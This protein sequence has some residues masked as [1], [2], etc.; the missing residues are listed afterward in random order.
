M[1][2]KY[3]VISIGSGHNGLIAAAYFA[4]AGRK[5]LV[6]EK[7]EH[8]GGGVVTREMTAP[9][10][11]HDEHSVAHIF[12]QAN[13]L[14]LNDELGLISRYGLKYT[15]PE[16]P[17]ISVFEDGSTLPVF[18]DVEKNRQ[19]IAQYSVRDADSFM[20]LCDLSARFLPMLLSSLY[21]PPLPV[22][23]MMAMLDQSPE[24]REIFAI[25]QKSVFDI[26]TEWFENEKV[27]IHFIKM[28]SENLVMPE[29]KGTGIG[30]F[31][32]LG[33]LQQYGVGVAVGGSGKLTEAL[34]RCI[35]DH[36]GELMT[37]TAVEKVLVKEGRAVG[38]RTRDE[39]YLAE[40]CVIGALHPHLLH[41]YIDDLDAGVD[42]RA[43]G[44]HLASFSAFV[45]HGALKEPMRF[46]AGSE[47]DKGWL[48]ELLPTRLDA[49]RRSFD[50][51][52]YG[53]TPTVPLFGAGCPSLLD[54]VRAPP[55]RATLYFFSYAPYHLA[56]GGA[57]RWDEIKETYADH[58]V[59]QLGKFITNIGPDNFIARN[60]RSPI[61]ME[62][63]SDSFQQGDIHGAAPFFYQFGAHRPTPDLGNYTVPGVSHLYLV[64]PFMHPGGG[65]FGAG[66]AAAMKAFED[67][68]MN[69][70][71][72]AT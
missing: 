29:E 34:V 65:V 54:P 1:P 10:F 31:M 32:F 69:F 11:L 6:V 16:V 25:M 45:V 14:I 61:D 67:L 58:L 72:A 23:A 35:Q 57:R 17:F 71:K 4:K 37:E 26:V 47:V 51:L 19:A 22:G 63:D 38:V 7:R 5:V 41:R 18:A 59:A 55:G 21:T 9:G 49:L 2:R 42:K 66:R 12:I 60:A 44:V 27:R 68:G 53:M 62:R 3:D 36:G 70:E 20:R 56:E 50:E 39:E 28:V 64:G 48:I 52:K 43:R 30:L 13:P 15:R 24:G 40:T 8:F 46:K 33:Y